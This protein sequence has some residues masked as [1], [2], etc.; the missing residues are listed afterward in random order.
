MFRRLSSLRGSPE[1]DPSVSDGEDL[2]EVSEPETDRGRE[3]PGTGEVSTR[4]PDGGLGPASPKPRGG[5][6]LHQ[7]EGPWTRDLGG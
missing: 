1:A 6:K 7:K 4:L 5:A 2:H 3:A